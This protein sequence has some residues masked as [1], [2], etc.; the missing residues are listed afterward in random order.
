MNILTFKS[1]GN[2]IERFKLFEQFLRNCGII[3]GVVSP[4]WCFALRIIP[5]IELERRHS[6]PKN[7]SKPR[8]PPQRLAWGDPLHSRF[9][10]IRN[11]RNSTSQVVLGAGLEPARISPYAPQAYVSANFT[12]RAGIEIVVSISYR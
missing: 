8:R 4:V 12:T 5:K 9:T 10:G 7:C 1:F 2:V 3:H 6:F 11:W